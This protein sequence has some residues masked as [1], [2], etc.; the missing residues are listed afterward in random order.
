MN[1]FKSLAQ[2]FRRERTLADLA[3]W[4]IVPESEL[5]A[6]LG[7]SPLWARGYDYSRFTIPKR[8][9]GVRTIEAPND[10]LKA[11]QRSVL[12]R[13]LNPLPMRQAATSFVPGRSI[14]DNARPHLG[15]AVVVNLDL[16]DFFPAI[17]VERVTEVW[18]GLGW[19]AEAASVLTRICTHEGHLPQGAPTSPALSNLVCR[20]LDARL[21]ALIQRSGGRYTRYADDITISLPGFGHSSAPPSAHYQLITRVREINW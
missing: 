8:R 15:R 3:R 17:T 9:G 12:R 4:L 19:G 21:E 16:A 18:A 2:S 13:L 20:R 6:W 5:R 1:L 7:D 10:K 14:V 11:L